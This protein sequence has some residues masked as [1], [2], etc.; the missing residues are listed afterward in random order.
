MAPTTQNI[1]ELSRSEIGKMLE[2]LERSDTP[3]SEPIFACCYDPGIHHFGFATYVCPVCG[4]KTVYSIDKAEFIENEVPSCRSLFEDLKKVAP[5]GLELD[6][7]W[8]CLRCCPNA[9]KT[10]LRLKI[11]YSN[12]PSVFI[13]PINEED[14]LMLK[15]FF[16]GSLSYSSLHREERPLKPRLLRLRRLLKAGKSKT[17]K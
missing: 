2:R 10:A 7:S 12:E 11:T 16:S 6:E 13:A 8:L 3:E 1:L 17:N 15:G 9:P 14:L 4:S 5:A